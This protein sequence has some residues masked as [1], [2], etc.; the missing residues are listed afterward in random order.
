MTLK[1][2]LFVDDE[3]QIL[4]GLGNLL[5]KHRKR[6]S[7]TFA[8]GADAALAELSKAPFDVVVTDMRMPGMDGAALLRR[9]KQSH[10]STA[11]IVLSGHAERDAIVASLSV[12]HQFLS[13][14]CAGD[15]LASVIERTCNLQALLHDGAVRDVIGRL[16]K[17]PSAP[18]AYLELVRIAADPDACLADMAHVIERDP[19]M[20]VKVLQVV[21]SAFFGLAHP[22]ASVSKAVNYLGAELLKG[23]AMSAHIFGMLEVAPLPGFSLERLQLQSLLCGRL[24]G[25][26][27]RESK[28]AEEAMTA[29]LVKDAGK[30]VLWQARPDDF[31]RVVRATLDSRRAFHLV[32]REIFGVTH[33]EV[34]AYLLGVWGLPLPIVEAVAFHDQPALVDQGPCEVLAAVHA[35]GALVDELER[36]GPPA[37]GAG[38]LD[39][40]FLKRVGCA[41]LVPQWRAAAEQEHLALSNSQRSKAG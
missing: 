22:M 23:L 24:A 11:R 14:P 36:G 13:K 39:L 30:L 2:I 9:V 12:A 1:K 6:W 20:A 21:N 10:P 25:R 29:A 40:A 27:A 8:L 38:G 32:E 16:D 34:G 19:A 5:R 18:T 33:A 3:Q 28:N 31:A 37:D 4:D 17:L 35:A 41:E 15:A 7:M 26:F